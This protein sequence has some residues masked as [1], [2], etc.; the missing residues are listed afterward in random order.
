MLTPRQLLILQV[1]VDDFIHSAQPVGSRTL[2]KK[3]ELSFSS[4]TIRNEMAD[5]EE[6]GYIEKTH[7]SSGRVPSEKGYRFYVDHLL[8]PKRLEGKEIEAV[9]SLFAA[10]MFELE[11]VVQ[12]SSQIL[13]ELTNYTSVVLGPK[14]KTNK[15]RSIQ[16]I[17]VGLNKAVAIIVTDTGLVQN[18]TITIPDHI[19]IGDIEKMVNILNNRL[20]G[21]PIVDLQD[22]IFKEVVSVLRGHVQNYE[23]IVK[24]LDGTFYIPSRQKVYTSGETNMLFQPEFHDIDKFR[25]FLTTLERE[26]EIKELLRK[27]RDGVHVMIG[28]E[29]ENV[30]MENCSIITATYSFGE[31]N[32]GT[33]AILGPKRMEYS[34]VISLLQYVAAGLS[35]FFEDLNEM[36]E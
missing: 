7:T 12:K 15:L 22:K 28:R 30:G 26:E 36:K 13:S 23:S 19:E 8:S 17:P 20:V 16:I 34:R 25:S 1:I 6:M 5:L 31:N 3:E 35:G 32:L 27:R 9:K 2:S 29:T 21:V 11:K 33:V 10:H 18:K 24:M 14:V 4:A